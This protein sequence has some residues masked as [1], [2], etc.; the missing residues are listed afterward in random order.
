MDGKVNASHEIR[1]VKNG[2]VEQYGEGVGSR[3]GAYISFLKFVPPLHPPCLPLFYRNLIL[4]C[5][6]SFSWFSCFLSFSFSTASPS[7]Y[8]FSSFLFPFLS[9][10][11]S[12]SSSTFSFLPLLLYSFFFRFLAGQTILSHILPMVNFFFTVFSLTVKKNKKKSQES[13]RI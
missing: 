9:S 7:A 4:S 8:S 10:F 12:S 5:V 13:Y 6:S 3:Q 1:K 2:I 11:T